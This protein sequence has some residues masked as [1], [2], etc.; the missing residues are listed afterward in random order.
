MH[1]RQMLRVIKFVYI[2]VFYSQRTIR[3]Q[4]GARTR[5]PYDVAVQLVKYGKQIPE[6][7]RLKYAVTRTQLHNFTFSVSVKPV[8]RLNLSSLR[9][10]WQRKCRRRHSLYQRNT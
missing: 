9:A 1:Q 5:V 4:V 8:A 3:V 6:Y 2:S 7:S 10:I